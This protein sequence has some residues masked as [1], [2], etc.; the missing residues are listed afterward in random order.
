PRLRIPEIAQRF[1]TH[2]KA[3]LLRLNSRLQ[4]LIGFSSFLDRKSKSRTAF[5]IF[6]AENPRF[7]QHFA[8]STENP[9]ILHSIRT[10]HAEDRKIRAAFCFFCATFTFS[11]GK[12]AMLSGGFV[13]RAEFEGESASAAESTVSALQFPEPDLFFNRLGQLFVHLLDPNPQQAQ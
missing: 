12:G 8:L 4:S 7:R 3:I 10:F 13:D 6:H 11:G 5:R 9:Q 2:G 1:G